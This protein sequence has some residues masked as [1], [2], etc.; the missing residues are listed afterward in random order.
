[1]P[2]IDGHQHFW[3]YQAAEHSWIT[4][5]MRVLRR[6]FLPADLVIHM[7]KHQIDGSIAVQAAQSMDET[8]FLLK[9]AGEHNYIA[10]VVGWVDL[11]R[12]DLRE[13]LEYYSSIPKL[14]GFRHLIQDE[15][16]SNYA[17]RPDFLRG[18]G[19]LHEYNL[20]FDVLI[21]PK[22]MDAALKMIERN[23][24]QSFILDH[25]AK[26]NI[27][28]GNTPGWKQFI[29]HLGKE[30][31]TFCKISGMVTEADWNNWSYEDLIP[32]LDEV[33]E[34]FG[35]DRIVFGSDWPVCLLAAEYEE[36]L[37]VVN[38]YLDQFDPAERLKVMGENCMRFYGL[39]GPS[40]K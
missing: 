19:L 15:E 5:D 27:I 10:G 33:V 4:S 21:Y 23:P 3:R 1:M 2:R 36:V 38:R 40:R 11:T 13:Q 26:P 25:L 16:D 6:D 31:N 37:M 18:L 7:E 12:E 8:E 29:R 22:Q 32:Y 17:I 20:T 14:V 9:L 34:N 28:H 39:D 24:N 35:L 30:T